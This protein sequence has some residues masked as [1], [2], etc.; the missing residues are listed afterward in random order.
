MLTDYDY[1]IFDIGA[2]VD[3]D[4]LSFILSVDEVIVITT[5]EPTSITD[6]Y[7]A[8]KYITMKN[9]RIPFYLLVNRA[10]SEKKGEDAYQRISTV[11]EHFLNKNSHFLGIVP[12]DRTV[13]PSCEKADPICIVK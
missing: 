9:N 12:E 7:A 1:I 3:E 10:T 2:G 5:P 8:M 4:S 6:A 13:P 11:L